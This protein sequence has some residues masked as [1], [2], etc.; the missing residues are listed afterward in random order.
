VSSSVERPRGETLLD[1]PAVAPNA[2]SAWGWDFAV[3]RVGVESYID[4]LPWENSLGLTVHK[5]A[6]PAMMWVCMTKPHHGGTANGQ[7]KEAGPPTTAN[8]VIDRLNARVSHTNRFQASAK[9]FET[10]ET[11]AMGLAPPALRSLVDDLLLRRQPP[12]EV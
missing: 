11:P 1:K 3:S 12:R 7:R 4:A 2:E 5:K 6:V 9:C 8:Q 10:E